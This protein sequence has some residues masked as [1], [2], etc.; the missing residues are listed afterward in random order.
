MN[1]DASDITIDNENHIV[2]VGTTYG[3]LFGANPRYSGYYYLMK[4][5]K[6]TGALLY[7][8]QFGDDTHWSIAKA[9]AIDSEN[10]AYISGQTYS[11]MY[12]DTKSGGPYFVSKH[13][14]SNGKLIWGV[15]NA[16]T[17]VSV[18]TAS[19]IKVNSKNEIIIGGYTT[20]SLFAQ[21]TTMQDVF[22]A[23]MDTTNG[24]ITW[25]VQ[26]SLNTQD[27]LYGM[28]LCD[29]NNIFVT[30]S[31]VTTKENYFVYKLSDVDGSK[32]W[33]VTY[34]SSDSDYGR[35][36]AFSKADEAL[37]VSGYTESSL[38]A[39][40]V[41]IDDLFNVKLSPKDGSILGSVQHG[42]NK[43]EIMTM[44]SDVD[45][46]GRLVTT[47]YVNGALYADVQPGFVTTS[48]FI[49]KYSIKSN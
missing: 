33:N 46:A 44:G 42:C 3:P 13:S 24:S 27:F 39:E 15:S 23:K 47:G 35:D 17:P 32:L 34:G 19:T 22:I 11:D 48:F 38:Y 2:V 31:T 28:T 43:C 10:N 29:E 21:M 37:Y 45:S 9:V 7:G 26:Y 1:D 4:L 14:A 25:G 20:D 6:D 36:I 30:G 18:S 41:G 8:V 16:K 49:N 40:K 5:N 12:G